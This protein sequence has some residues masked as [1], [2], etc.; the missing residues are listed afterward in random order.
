[1]EIDF[2]EG[3]KVVC[4][5]IENYSNI[6]LGEDYTAIDFSVDKTDVIIND[7]NNN[8]C[9]YPVSLFAL[10]DKSLTRFA[11][12]LVWAKKQEDG[13][14]QLWNSL[15]SG[16]GINEED[17]LKKAYDSNK[18]LYPNSLLICKGVLKL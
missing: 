1:M 14:T 11:V 6:T 4:I 17:V 10:K 5:D 18:E 15:Y 7:D 9:F 8:E 13:T 3:D 16:Y 2:K 12:S